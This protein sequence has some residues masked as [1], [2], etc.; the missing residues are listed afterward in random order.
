MS[1]FEYILWDWNGTV[2]DDFSSNLALI[3]HLLRERELP[4]ITA[5]RYRTIF[6]FPIIDFYRSAGFCCE[7]EEYTRLVQ[8]Y[9]Y[10]YSLSISSI[11]LVQGVRDIFELAQ[12]N[13]MEQIILSASN[14]Q[15]IRTQMKYYGDI[16]HYFSEIIAQ[17]N[18]FAYG[19]VALAEK[20]LAESDIHNR[21]RVVIIGDT[22]YDYKISK[23][24]NCDCF[25]VDV[26]HQDLKRVRSELG[27]EY[28]PDMITLRQYLF[29]QQ[30]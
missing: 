14:K 12:I 28:I 10:K 18:D 25:L 27:I 24:L 1:K 4:V 17:D 22:R 11:P 16:D 13:G 29:E 8:E 6:T 3:N 30:C 19:K 15:T 7:G 21:K 23:Q 9:S 26:G 5:E 2:V 20:W